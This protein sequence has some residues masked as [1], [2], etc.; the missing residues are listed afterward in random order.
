MPAE[1]PP[2]IRSSQPPFFGIKIARNPLKTKFLRTSNFARAAGLLALAGLGLAGCR[3]HAAAPRTHGAGPPVVVGHTA[4]KIVPL[5]LE[6]IGVVEPSRTVSVRSQVTGSLLKIDFAE[7]HD[8]KAGD[9]LFEIDPRPFQNALRSA[10]ADLQKAHVQLENARSQSARYRALNAESAISKEQFQTIE[11]NERTAAAQVHS[12]EA[13]V[14]SARLQLDYCSIR[15]PIAGRTSAY[16]VH[17]GDLVSSLDPTPLV[18]INQVSPTYVTFG[19]PQQHL[20]DL[21]RYRAAGT[22]HV[23]ATPSGD[24]GPPETGE[25]IFIDN[26]VDS[27]TG[28]LKLKAAFPNESH[29][30]WPGQFVTVS[31]TLASPEELVVPSAAVQNDQDGQ[32]VF[33]VRAD[34]TAEFRPIVV[35]RES[36]DDTVVS[37]GLAAGET[38]I[39]DGQLRVLPG[40]PVQIKPAAAAVAAE[41]AAPATSQTLAP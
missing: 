10:E 28:M 12:G 37:H 31:V 16:G 15:A 6:A 27:T 8:V 5:A 23:F 4:R 1:T 38:V 11:D 3:D 24:S 18:V 26:N 21:R 7:G 29:R 14:A 17:E 20:D 35:A 25:L 19:V 34:G 40:Q 22:V 9:L 32:H 41:A 13:A 30:L 33:I 39:V 36:G 2:R